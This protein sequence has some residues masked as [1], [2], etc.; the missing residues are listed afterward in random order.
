MQHRPSVLFSLTAYLLVSPSLFLILSH[1]TS[2]RSGADEPKLVHP[3][4]IAVADSGDVFVAD[5]KLPGVWQLHGNKLSIYFKAFP[6]LQSPLSAVRCVELDLDGRLL[7]GDSATRDVYRFDQTG[8]P[9][10]LTRRQGTDLSRD[11]A[12]DP[13]QI[14]IPIDIAVN[15]AGDIFVSDLEIGRVVKLAKDGPG[16]PVEIAQISACRGLSIDSNDNLWIISTTADQLHCLSPSGDHEVVVPGSVF[17]FPHTVAVD[18]RGTAYVCDGYGPAIW[19]IPTGQPPEQWVQGEPLV[20][21]VGMALYK[22]KLLIADPGARAIFQID[23][24]GHLSKLEL[25]IQSP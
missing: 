14:G 8:Q 21:P 4:S 9:Q 13:G 5:R 12:A 10:S 16:K 15:R 11:T 2:Q 17:S 22:D 20:N 23:A 24:E 7:V 1:L 3:V 19:R 25:E 18:D 6:H